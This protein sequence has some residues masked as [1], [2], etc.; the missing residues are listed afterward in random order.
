[1]SPHSCDPCRQ[2]P[3]RLDEST[4][5]R[6]DL[7]KGPA[8][9]TGRAL[10]A[11]P[12]RSVPVAFPRFHAPAPVG[13]VGDEDAGFDAQS[14]GKVCDRGVDRHNMIEQGNKC[15]R[16]TEIRQRVGMAAD[17]GACRQ[18]FPFLAAQ[19]DPEKVDSAP[20]GSAVRNKSR[21]RLRLPSF[22]WS[23]LPR[24][25]KPM[26]GLCPGPRRPCHLLTASAGA[27]R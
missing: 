14:A 17:V 1:M 20:P 22:W 21:S 10:S 4:Q 3:I 13:C 15:R 11:E 5:C 8:P 18:K 7:G 16:I 9:V 2:P 19:V 24:K 27:E 12:D 6:C 23:G 25:A 26:R